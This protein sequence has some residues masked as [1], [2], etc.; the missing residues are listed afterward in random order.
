MI[1]DDNRRETGARELKPK[2]VSDANDDFSQK[3]AENKKPPLGMRLTERLTERSEGD[4]S[5]LQDAPS[6][7]PQSD[8]Q[9]QSE[10]KHA[11]SSNDGVSSADPRVLSGKKHGD[12]TF[13]LKK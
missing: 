13:P 9:G 8:A 10:R 3:A 4:R 5:D 7:T 6:G 12:A 2:L 11:G 1:E